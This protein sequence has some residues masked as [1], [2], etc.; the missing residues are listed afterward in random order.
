MH[1]ISP[2]EHGLF[3]LVLGFKSG[4]SLGKSCKRVRGCVCTWGNVCLCESLLFPSALDRKSV[5]FRLRE[6]T[7]F[8]LKPLVRNSLM[9][10]ILRNKL[11]MDLKGI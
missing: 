2:L 7:I 5:R 6:E 1:Q 3:Q 4:V 11:E 8:F 9:F 10:S